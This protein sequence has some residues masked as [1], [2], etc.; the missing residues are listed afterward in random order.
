MILS[1]NKK[2]SLLPLG[3]VKHMPIKFQQSFYSHVSDLVANIQ[4]EELVDSAAVFGDLVHEVLNQVN[5]SAVSDA[6]EMYDLFT[7]AERFWQGTRHLFK[8]YRHS[9]NTAD[10]KLAEKALDMFQRMNCPRLLLSNAGAKLAALSNNI[11][12]AWKPTDLTGTFLETWAAQ[13]AT[14]AGDYSTALQKHIERGAQHVCYTERKMDLY[15][16]FEFLYLNIYTFVGNTG[17]V[18]IAQVF[19]DINDLIAWYTATA[20][21]HATRVKNANANENE[22]GNEN[23]NPSDE[24]KDPEIPETEFQDDADLE[25]MEAVEN[26]KPNGYENEN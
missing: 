5:A 17:D 23:P 11:N 18:Q 10:A 3:F 16:A 8:G 25:G 1:N 20:K 6:Q 24:A 19:A 4:N 15:E 9:I 2:A 13:L 14:L 7:R 12:T 21:A 26:E 22:N